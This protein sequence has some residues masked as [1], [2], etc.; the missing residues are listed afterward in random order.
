MNNGRPLMSIKRPLPRIRTNR[1]AFLWGAGGVAL[2][3][4][5]LEGLPERS[6]WAQ[7][8]PPQFLY[9]M[10]AACGVVASDFFPSD[11]GA[12]TTAALQ[13]SGKAVAALADHADSLL[14][15]D[16]VNYPGNLTN[17]GHAQGLVQSLTGVGPSGGGSTTQSTGISADMVMSNELNPAGTDPLTLYSG[18]KSYIAERISFTGPGNARPAE[19]NPY[20]V[21]RGL[22]GLVGNGADGTTSAGEVDSTA[23]ELITRETSVNDLIRD[24]LQSLLARSD[25]SAAD[26][27]RLDAHLTAVRELE[28]GMVQVATA[29]CEQAE[30]DVSTI[31]S[32]QNLQYSN[33]NHMIEQLV[34]LHSEL[35]ALAF[36]CNANR[37]ATIQWGDG[38]DGSIYDVPSNSRKWKFH[39]VSHRMQSDGASGNDPTALEA[40]KEIDALRMETLKHALDHFA[41][42]GLFSNAAIVW[43]NHVSDG[44]SHSFRNIPYVIGGSLGGTLKQGQY[45]SAGNTSN[46]NLLTTLIQKAG[47]SGSVGNGSTLDAILA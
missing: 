47:S 27:Q 1:R 18:A 42:R 16:G 36:A 17:C 41:M 9:F 19:R 6:A 20:N 11:K 2:G 8:D 45:V 38:T 32:M 24:D 39:H 35:V 13:S 30:L 44:P 23:N 5:F 28:M 4:P 7:N 15:V 43:T 10:V 34:K 12:I 3:L 29:G 31:E 22:V 33:N 37:V 40:H 26:R 21:Y 25:L 14:L 46:A